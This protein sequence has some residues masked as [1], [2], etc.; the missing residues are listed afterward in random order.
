MRR[1]VARL[2]TTSLSIVSRD[3]LA[4]KTARGPVGGMHK[5][6]FCGAVKTPL[7]GG[8][9]RLCRPAWG[10]PAP[11][12]LT[13]GGNEKGGSNSFCEL[14]SLVLQFRRLDDCPNGPSRA[15]SR[16]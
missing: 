8:A 1:T 6:G 10:E 5:G 7:V 12:R 16:K 9:G 15:R 14:P 4:N 3:L 2:K 13:L 11:P